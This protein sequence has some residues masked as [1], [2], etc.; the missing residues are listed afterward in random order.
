MN[1][2]DTYMTALDQFREIAQDVDLD[3]KAVQHAREFHGRIAQFQVLIPLVG[4][5]NAGKTSLANAYLEREESKELPT[6]IVPQT[7]LATEIHSASSDS[8]E[9]IELYG[10][11]DQLLQ[12]VDIAEFQRVEKETL[13][14]GEL[15]AQYAKAM[16]HAAPLQEDDRKV[17]VDMP[18]LDSGLRTHNAAIQRYLPL[19]S[20][21]ILVVDAEHGALRDSEIRQL[22]EFLDQEIEFAVLINKIDKK[23]RDAETIAEHIEEQVHQAFGKSAT[24][25]LVSAHEGDIAAFRQIVEAIDFDHALR[26]YWRLRILGLFDD[27]IQS[28]H[29]RYSALNV[30]SAD[31]ERMIAQLKKKKEA[32]EEKF[33]EDEREIRGRYSE[34][35][36]NRILRSVRN[37]IRDNAPT[38]VQIHQARGQQA[39]NQEINEL[40][41]Q[42]LNRT[43]DEERSETLREV[44]ERYQADIEEIGWLHEQFVSSGGDAAF[45]PGVIVQAASQ[46]IDAGRK[47]AKAFGVAARTLS[48]ARTLS[49]VAGGIFAATT[50]IVAPW[51]EVVIILLPSIIGFLSKRRAEKQQQEQMQNQLRELRSQIENVVAPKIASELRDSITE[52]YGKITQEMLAQLREQVR[53]DI[54]QIQAD[55]DKSRA[56]IKEQRQEVE[57]RKAQLHDAIDRLTE[58]KKPLEDD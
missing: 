34:R 39:F 6:D 23:K 33:Q 37:T 28:L 41:R 15:S 57:D 27:A 18:G 52:D 24:V 1:V 3:E 22:R 48:K 50:S 21:F 17:L 53:G 40:V 2:Q 12:R 8:E 5:F 32:L 36:V 45:E 19:G 29:T 4:S 49:T 16:L 42:T 51:L 13:K 20:Y 31:N 44:V 35:A 54:E 46:A 30:S 58:T 14:T 56:E 55:I 9:R 26:G 7:A 25:R 10:K 47:S 43:L 38:L 11:D